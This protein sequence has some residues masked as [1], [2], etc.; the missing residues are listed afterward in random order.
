MSIVL[1]ALIPTFLIIALA[2][3]MKRVNVL[4]V[5]A[6]EGMERA[7][8]FIFFP[9]FLFHSL[10]DADFGGYNVWALTFALL[11]GI[12]VMAIVLAAL[13]HRMG[14]DG[15]QYSSV[16]QGA[17]RWN[18]FVA[19]ATLQGLHGALGASLSAVAFAAIVPVVNT[20]SVLTLT[21]HANNQTSARI[22]INNLIANPL[23]IACVA[24]IAWKASG[25]IM[26]GPID[27]AINILA[28]A[29]VPLGLFTVGAGLDFHGLR[30]HPRTLGIVA[31]LK[32]ILMPVLMFAF[33]LIYGV[34]GPARAVAVVAGAVPTATSAYILARQLGG[35][36]TL[37]ANIVTATTI[38]A[39][40]SMPVMIW[41]LT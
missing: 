32:L 28:V 16:Y 3:A 36:A 7:T 25:L 34:T 4:S 22:V 8:Y 33:C 13:R 2:A 26:P 21:R 30:A 14:I 10:A 6:W 38:L 18:G 1:A 15:A 12:S 17:I 27:S 39:F 11:S 29:S 20:L 23:I 9:A 40:I 41:L 19:V 5:P 35:D 37:M 24:G 31:A